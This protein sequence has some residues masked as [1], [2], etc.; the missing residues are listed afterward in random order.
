MAEYEVIVNGDSTL[1][2]KRR[3]LARRKIWDK[4]T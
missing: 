1:D 4:R 2:N 3:A